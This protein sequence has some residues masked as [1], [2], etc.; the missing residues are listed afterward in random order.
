MPHTD[1]DLRLN[2]MDGVSL[3]EGN[4]G[5]TAAAASSSSEGQRVNGD[6]VMEYDGPTDGTLMDS[7]HSIEGGYT[8]HPPGRVFGAYRPT[9]GDGTKARYVDGDLR[10]SY[11]RSFIVGEGDPPTAASCSSDAQGV[12]R[13]A[14]RI[15]TRPQEAGNDSRA[16][17]QGVPHSEG[18]AVEDILMAQAANAEQ[19]EDPFGYGELN[20]DEGQA[21]P[22]AAGEAATHVGEIGTNG[23]PPE[24][25]ISARERRKL[26]LGQAAE[27]NKR[28]RAESEALTRAW[29]GGEAAVSVGSYL[30]LPPAQA[31]PPSPVHPTHSLVV[32]GGFTGCVRCGRVVA[33]QCHGRFS[34]T[35]RGSCPLGS[36]RPIRRLIKGTFPH[37][38]RQSHLAPP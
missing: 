21:T 32:C 27:R 18:P 20:F 15:C 2:D 8:L 7:G 17:V 10:D 36:Q 12:A 13:S 37:D 24:L 16:D 30:E 22:R 1:L 26:I 6:A 38:I 25:L 34:E 4:E 9:I 23:Q 31:A 5:E 28:K 3:N 11:Q 33:F 19:C 29:S 14:K 35:C